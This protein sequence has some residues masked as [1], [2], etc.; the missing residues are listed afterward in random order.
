MNAQRAIIG[1]EIFELDLFAFGKPIARHGRQQ[2]YLTVGQAV[3]IPSFGNERVANHP[4]RLTGCRT[5]GFRE[6]NVPLNVAFRVVH[7]KIPRRFAHEL[8]VRSRVE[9]VRKEP[10]DF[11]N[12]ES[13][14]TRGMQEKRLQSGQRLVAKFN[15]VD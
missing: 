14:A 1:W 11:G 13:I 7:A 15:I 8:L 9:S 3:F 2:E 4:Q 10:S 5:Q 12:R 6:R